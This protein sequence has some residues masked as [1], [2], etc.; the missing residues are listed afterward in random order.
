M[1]AQTHSL[2]IPKSEVRVPHSEVPHSEV[3]NSSLLAWAGWQIWIPSEWQPLKLEGTP[4]KGQVIVG[5]D[6][7]AIFILKW[8]RDAKA[9]ISDG[10]DWVADRLKQHGVLPELDPPGESHFTACGWTRG[11][12][13]EEEK[14]TTHWYGYNAESQLLLGV[15]INGV[16][17][18]DVRRRVEGEVLPTLLTTAAGSESTWAM[19][20]VSFCVPPGYRLLQR[21]LFSG[22]IALEFGRGTKET[23]LLRQVYP[24]ELALGRRTRAQWLEAYPFKVHRRLRRHSARETAWRCDGRPELKGVERMAWKRLPVPMGW[25]TPRRTHSV[26]V[27]DGNLDRLLLAEH[28]AP[29][30]VDP[31]LCLRA[32]ERMNAA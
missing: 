5:D 23:L 27:H 20:D 1:T 8:Q 3:P 25:C 4:E 15:T 18:Q 21:H 6:S 7:C 16:L 30:E 29:R 11:V 13:T 2:D 22:D 14:E 9:R 31:R 24:G 32:I 17:P 12:Q 19:Y 28:Q 26:A 10:Q